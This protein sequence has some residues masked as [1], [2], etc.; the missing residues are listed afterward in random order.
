M[1]NRT[2]EHSAAIFDK[3]EIAVPRKSAKKIP[4]GFILYQGP[5]LLE[6]A[7]NILVIAT[8]KS[9]NDKTGNMV[10]TFIIRDDMKPSDAVKH[11][12]DAPICGHCPHAGKTCYVN[13]GQSV[14]SVYRAYLRG[15]YP[16]ATV[17]D[18]DKHMTGRAIRFGAY[19]D[20]AAAPF[21]IWRML[22]NTASTHTGYTH[23]INHKAFDARL[24]SLVMIS[25]DS[26]KQ[27]AKYQAKGYRTFR[28]KNE[29]DGFAEN[30]IECLADSDDMQCI[31]CGL[32]D[33]ANGRPNIAITV[34]GAH[35]S[36]FKTANIIATSGV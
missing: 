19:G 23:Q 16:V 10:Q 33:G 11:R 35:A 34:H 29:H 17:D 28:V 14:N 1:T 9:S 7:I 25:A 26:P 2:I 24:T 5:S 8:L 36:Q 31:D 22:A 3:S 15:S 18:I 30:E 6:P 20:P 13:T 4:P 21:W 12:E 32:C 27:A